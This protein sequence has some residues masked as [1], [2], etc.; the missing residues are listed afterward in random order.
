MPIR[1]NRK[2]REGDFFK[3]EKGAKKKAIGKK[4]IETTI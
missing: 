1:E 3:E 4:E 2:W